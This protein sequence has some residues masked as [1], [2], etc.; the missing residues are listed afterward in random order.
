MWLSRRNSAQKDVYRMFRTPRL[1]VA[2]RT[3]AGLSQPELAAEAGIAPSVLGAIEQGR[4]DPRQS[5]VLAIIDALKARGVVLVPESDRTA[6]GVV[7]NKGSASA[8]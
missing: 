5:T 4:S 6:W 8:T 1:L 7:V 2:A 3:L